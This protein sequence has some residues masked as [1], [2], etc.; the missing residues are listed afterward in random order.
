MA[1]ER[2]S[3]DHREETKEGKSEKENYHVVKNHQNVMP[4]AK[5]NLSASFNP[6][7]KGEKEKKGMRSVIIAQKRLPKENIATIT[8]TSLTLHHALGAES[9]LAGRGSYLNIT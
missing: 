4:S 8:T 3:K 6:S 7:K 9:Y 5:A 2:N 1:K